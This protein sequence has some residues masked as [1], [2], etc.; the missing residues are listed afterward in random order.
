M[1]AVTRLVD[2]FVTQTLP[3]ESL[4]VDPARS[5]APPLVVGVVSV[6]SMVSAVL[7]AMTNGGDAALRALAV[8]VTAVTVAT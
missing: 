7:E 5:R 8:G 1:N 4:A 6:V 3:C 2:A